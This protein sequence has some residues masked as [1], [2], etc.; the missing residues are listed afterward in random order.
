MHFSLHSFSYRMFE[1]N[2]DEYLDEE[3]A[4]VKRAF[5]RICKTWD[6]QVCERIGDTRHFY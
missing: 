4:D 1:Q 6:Q 3:V 5:D 2:M